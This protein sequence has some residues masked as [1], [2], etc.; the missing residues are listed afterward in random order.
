MFVEYIRES[1]CG[2]HRDRKEGSWGF[3]V[4]LG[5]MGTMSPY[6][7]DDSHGFP[8]FLPE[9]CVRTCL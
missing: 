3:S 7:V 8:Q 2:P 1:G 4:Y 5:A 9:Q 6:L